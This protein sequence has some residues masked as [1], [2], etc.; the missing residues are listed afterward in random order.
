MTPIFDLK[1]Q[2]EALAELATMIADRSTAEVSLR[3]NREARETVLDEQFDIDRKRVA[4]SHE[5][6]LASLKAEHQAAVEKLRLEFD[7]GTQRLAREH[8]ERLK[9]IASYFESAEENARGEQKKAR[10]KSE[11]AFVTSGHELDQELERYKAELEQHRTTLTQFAADA[12]KVV[13]RR[14][15]RRAAREV[16]NP[17]AAP[18]V[19]NAP[20]VFG[21]C[22]ARSRES[23][24][25][26]AGQWASR[27]LRDGLPFFIAFAAFGGAVMPMGKMFG[28]TEWFWAATSGAIGV[29]AGLIVYVI[30]RPI[31]VQQTVE[32][33]GQC[34]QAVADGQAAID[35]AIEQKIKEIAAQRPGLAQRRDAQFREADAALD[36]AL[37]RFAQEKQS[38]VTAA[39]EQFQARRAMI[40]QTSETKLRDAHAAQQTRLQQMQQTHAAEDAE[41]QRRFDEETAV[42]RQTFDRGWERLATR[43]HTGLANLR[44]ELAEGHGVLDGWYPDLAGLSWPEWKPGTVVP[45]ALRFGRYRVDL[46]MF[47]HGIPDTPE[48]RPDQTAFEFPAVLTYPGLTSLLIEAWG[49]GRREASEALRS[50]MLRYL[51]AL[52][53]GKVRFTIVDPTGLGQNFS[54]FMHLA[55][56]DDRLVTNRIW[57]EPTHIQQRLVDLTEHMEKVIQKYLRN[58]FPSISAYNE[59]A[60]EVAEPFHVLVV[61]NFPAGFSDE[62]A[63]RLVSIANSG[64]RC[65]VYTL[66]SVDTRMNLPRNFD[67]HD[68]EQNAAVLQWT[69]EGFRWLDEAL[70]SL[71][72]T[73]EAPPADEV[74][75]QAVRAAGRHAMNAFKVEVPFSMVAPPRERWWTWDSREEIQAPL[76]R[77]GATKLQAMRLGKG[78]SQHVL[79]AGKTGSGKSTLLHAMVVNLAL[80]YSPDEVQFY[81]I[82]FKKG[83]EF[84]QYATH[85]LPHARVI[86]IES[87]REFGMSVLERLDV[88]L[89]R[90]GDLFRQFGV[91]N[92]QGFR[93]ATGQPLPRVLLMVDEFQELF[94]QDDKIAQDASL[95]FD[96]LVRQGR[97]FGIH[98]LLGSQTLAGAYSLARS[99]LGQMA[100]RIALQCSEADS[101]LILSEDNTAARLLNRPGEAIYNDAN[102]LLE[103]N[104]PFQVVWLP[105]QELENYLAG[106]NELATQQRLNLDPAIVF[107]G[108]APADPRENGALRE[109]LASR[110][111]GTDAPDGLAPKAWLGSAVSI[112]EP[113]HV[114]FRR[115]SG[116]NLLVVGQQEEETLPLLANSLIGL[117]A[118]SPDA[119]R[120]CVLDGSRPESPE[121]N[122]WKNFPD[123]LPRLEREILVHHTA[124]ETPRAVRAELAIVAPRDVATGLSE[125]SAELQR[126]QESN[127][128]GAPWFLVVYNLGRFRELRR[129]DDDFGFGMSDD[130]PSANPAKQ[131]AA[132]LRDGPPLGLHTLIW[133]DTFN[134]LS[135]WFDRATLRELDL[136][137][138]F[139]MSATDSS[140]LMDTPAASR[141]GHHRALL[142]S[143]EQGFTEKFRPYG[144]AR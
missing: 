12:Q 8:D 141:L 98:V 77:A 7:L 45:E 80:H 143:E 111:A 1:R 102:G 26:F 66:I 10:R 84:K 74:F 109:A 82:D 83:V 87:E 78:T 130:S 35:L 4:A 112:K 110:V 64:A 36:A 61:A 30:L 55:D 117:M 60:G 94:V 40:A 97:A 34:V 25:E 28:W 67:L 103:G 13:R 134:N 52:P 115:Q 92:V 95:L 129:S 108:N 6:D 37:Q 43:W 142:H 72:L 33:Y 107:E 9:K 90:R 11:V 29:A 69:G 2:R 51:T 15:C 17:T 23:V 127:A 68:L 22:L 100:V 57:T 122:F 5:R 106:L 39:Q 79:I 24:E 132:L 14:R 139:Q 49:E 50:V 131:F 48:L 3:R 18:V 89:K 124:A 140:N 104:H 71:P 86:A 20:E 38:Q 75:T 116:A 65:G 93:D 120:F 76:G 59:Y 27:L 144:L 113:T 125:F 44:R 137:V 126:R 31:A 53:A 105:G 119:A 70:A 88:E 118:T 138:L 133:C 63:Q 47:E 123:E 73:L 56:F 81:L 85:R 101:H 135:R 19:G 42:N 32:T 96:R 16:E 62:A 136:R 46:E 121:V 128:V 54:A 99:T 114:V 91:Q 58:E 21:A 41:L